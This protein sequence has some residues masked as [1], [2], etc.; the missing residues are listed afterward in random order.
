MLNR[1]THKYNRVSSKKETKNSY[2][3]GS[4]I[5]FFNQILFCSFLNIFEKFSFDAE[6]T[7]G[8]MKERKKAR[9]IMTFSLSSFD[10]TFHFRYFFIFFCILFACSQLNSNK[11][12][13]TGHTEREELFN[14]NFIRKSRKRIHI[15]VYNHA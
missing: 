10:F 5:K 13:M 7:P 12:L 1:Q 14:R 4:S 8:E 2:Q 9:H 6:N 11:C 15:Y 3:Y